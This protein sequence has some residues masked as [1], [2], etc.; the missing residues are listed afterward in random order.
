MHRILMVLVFAFGLLAG[1]AGKTPAPRPANVPKEA[2][3][4]EPGM[5]EHKDAKG[6]TWLYRRTPFGVAKYKPDETAGS[7]A[8][9]E[10]S[11]LQ[12]FDEGENVRF[13]RK[14]PFGVSKW[15]RRKSELAGAE[16][17]AW[18]RASESKDSTKSKPEAS[19]Q[20]KGKQE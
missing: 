16:L 20:A 18:K 19:K 1:E 8:D 7:S 5:W 3:E 2:R 13:E 4:I 11:R 17:A 15:T 9:D 6:E 12:A 10:A 14:T